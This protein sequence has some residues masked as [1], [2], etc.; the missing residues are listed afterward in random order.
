MV[1]NP[2]DGHILYDTVSSRIGVDVLWIESF[3]GIRIKSTSRIAHVECISID[4]EGIDDRLHRDGGRV[5]FLI[6]VVRIQRHETDHEGMIVGMVVPLEQAVLAELLLSKARDHLSVRPKE[7]P[8]VDRRPRG[9][10]SRDTSRPCGRDVWE[11]AR[12][13]LRTGACGGSWRCAG[14]HRE[15]EVRNISRD[16]GLAG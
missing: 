7:G 4:T 3:H 10:G 8:T 6:V 13:R 14:S 9:D 11:Y 2:G 15:G 12:G 5:D 16:F 1:Y